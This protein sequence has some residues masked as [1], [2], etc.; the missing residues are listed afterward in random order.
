MIRPAVRVDV[1]HGPS[2]PAQFCE[3]AHSQFHI[4][5]FNNTTMDKPSTPGSSPRMAKAVKVASPSTPPSH[6]RKKRLSGAFPKTPDHNTEIPFSPSMKRTSLDSPGLKTPRHTGYDEDHKRYS[7]GSQYFSPGRKLFD[8]SP[9]KEELNEISSQ[10]RNRLS[11]ALGKLQEDPKKLT[12]TELSVESP[13]KKSRTTDA[14]WSPSLL[15][16]RANLN[17]QTL[18]HLPGTPSTATFE[19]LKQSPIIERERVQMPLPTEET[20]AHDALKAA[21][22]RQRRRNSKLSPKR[23]SMTYDPPRTP[24]QPIKLPSLNVALKREEGTEQEAVLLLMSLSS[25][26]TVSFTHSR[27]HSFGSPANQPALPVQTLPPI[28]G[29]IKAVGDDDATDIEDD[30]VSES[31]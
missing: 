25:P 10:L 3:F 9:N 2:A 4:S 19:G 22:S 5:G 30:T 6:A 11:S 23:K 18:Q 26:Q 8:E 7:R 13:T 24:S 16:Q 20:S 12:F 21:L 1:W 29:L 17:L 14:K 31:D 28:L 27:T 15:V